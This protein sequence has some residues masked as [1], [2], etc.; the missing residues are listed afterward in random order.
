MSQCRCASGWGGQFCEEQ[1]DQCQGQPCHNGG[2]CESGSGW[3]RCLCAKGFLG[4]DCRINVNECSP[5][6]CL[7]GATCIDGIG[8]FTCICPP[9]RRGARCE[10]CKYSN[11]TSNKKKKSSECFYY[12]M[13]SIPIVLSDPTSVCMNT[14][15]LSPYKSLA[16]ENEEK[17][18]FTDNELQTLQ[19]STQDEENCNACVCENGKPKCTNL[20][21][22]LPNCI[23]GLLAK[24][25]NACKKHEV[26]VPALR[27]SCLTG[28]CIA[29]GD[30]RVLEPSRRVAP[31]KLPAHPNCWPN[32]AELNTNCARL[33]ILL[34]LNTMPRGTSIENVCATLRQLLAAR[35]VKSDVNFKAKL[36]V[37]CD[38]KM[39]TND[40]IEVTMVS[41]FVV[42]IFCCLVVRWD[43]Y[44]NE[45]QS[46]FRLEVFGSNCSL[47]G[48]E[49]L[50]Y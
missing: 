25:K 43:G 24:N 16:L 44:E 21:C 36:F 31:P 29:R 47:I 28:G 49:F 33:T 22:G 10:I 12:Y 23:G 40:S 13:F 37:L 4:P 5:Q 11:K 20:W 6:P 17:N 48:L 18:N 15:T 7:G 41:L 39:G 3:F 27:E 42:V 46:I 30:C 26:C 34:Q 50:R 35:L 19:I 2:T 1:I 45:K 14:T 32:Q 9:G 8:G 38:L